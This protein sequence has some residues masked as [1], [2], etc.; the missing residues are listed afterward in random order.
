M[1]ILFISNLVPDRKE[2]WNP[3]FTRSGQNVIRGIAKELPK[4]DDTTLAC[5]LPTASFPHGPLWI[6]GK[7]DVLEDG[8]KIYI[9]PTLNIQIIKIIFWGIYSLY[10][11]GKWAKEHKNDQRRVLGYNIYTPP[12]KWLYKACRKT[13][14]QLHLILMDLGVPPKRLG[15]SKLRMWGYKSSEKKAHQFIPKLDGRI[16]INE[17]MVTEYA[18][19]KDFI[20]VD[21][22]INDEIISRLFPL[23]ESTNRT[24]TYVLAGMLWDQNGTK[25]VLDALKMSPELDVKVIFAG[26]GN[27]VSL[28]E[29]AAKNDHRI[30]Y[31][32]MLS[33]DQLL[34]VYESADVLLNLRIE[35]EVD[36]HFPSKLLECLTMGKLVL[37][38]PVAHAERD[39]GLYMKVLHDITPEGL[40]KVMSD[41]ALISKSDLLEQGKKAR[42][43]M[44]K[45]RTWTVRTKEIV[46]YM[47]SKK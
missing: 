18:P 20:L 34:K 42:S 1:A 10:F 45:N 17:N 37:S 19:N 46:E 29:T 21:G 7:V 44:L 8:Q 12:I 27:D 14:S 13:Q 43:F 26:K 11:V 47:N 30:E 9:W 5:C 24:V 38:T 15:L 39:Y 4:Y 2:Y 16:V 33:L 41:I 32:G 28:I 31:V 25:L 6:P 22:G 40:S 23:K 36:M 3:A 35:E